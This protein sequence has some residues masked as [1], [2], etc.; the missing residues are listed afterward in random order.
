MSPS[1]EILL[2]STCG[3]VTGR[4]CSTGRTWKSKKNTACSGSRRN[5]L[6][7]LG[8]Q[9]ID[10]GAGGYPAEAATDLSEDSMVMSSFGRRNS[11]SSSMTVRSWTS[12]AP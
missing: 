1:V 2:G 12:A 4:S 8:N 3:N 11:T 10:A 7:H 6:Q 9:K 5:G